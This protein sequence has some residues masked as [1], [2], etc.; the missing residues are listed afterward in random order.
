MVV[1]GHEDEVQVQ[2]GIGLEDLESQREDN[3]REC[4]LGASG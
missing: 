4:D 2:V 1:F 3:L